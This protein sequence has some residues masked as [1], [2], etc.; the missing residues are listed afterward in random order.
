MVNLFKKIMLLYLIL[1]MFSLT[2]CNSTSTVN[3]L[4]NAKP[5]DSNFVFKYG[6][7]VKNES[8]TI[9]LGYTKDDAIAEFKKDKNS[10]NYEIIQCVLKD[11]D[12]VPILKAVISFYD[13][14]KDNSCNLAFICSGFVQTMSFAVNEVD[15]IKTF[16][17]AD[18]SQLTYIRN[19]EV[20]TSI[21]KIKT[22]QNF[23]YRIIF[24]YNKS[25]SSINM[26]VSS[27]KHT[28]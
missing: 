22:N 1:A 9:K 8:N 6:V 3:E 7:N 12:K 25:T 26:A 4:S 16:E 15:G 5:K 19:G 2:G 21:R 17:I 11:D 27:E 10:T 13:K 24:S 23:D 18:G 28:K 14:E 20:T